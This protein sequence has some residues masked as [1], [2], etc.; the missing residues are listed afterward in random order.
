MTDR[1]LLREKIAERGVMMKFLA[2]KCGIT[3]QAFSM[4]MSGE[5]EFS[6]SEVATLRK[7]L[8]L[9]DDEFLAIFFSHEVA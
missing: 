7:A 1:E 5:R 9:S 3:A 8:A 6:L 4:K 2:E